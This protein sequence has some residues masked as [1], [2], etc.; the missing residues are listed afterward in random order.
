MNY[1]IVVESSLFKDLESWEYWLI[2]EL[3]LSTEDAKKAHTAIIHADSYKF[4]SDE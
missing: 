4:E 2:T 1:Q 3:G